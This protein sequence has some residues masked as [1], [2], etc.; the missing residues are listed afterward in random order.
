MIYLPAAWWIAANALRRHRRHQLLTK[1]QRQLKIYGPAVLCGIA[2]LLCWY[3]AALCFGMIAALL[4]GVP[5][6]L[7]QLA[8]GLTTGQV[9]TIYVSMT[10]G[11]LAVDLAGIYA[12]RRLMRW[13]IPE[14]SP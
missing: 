2:T 1:R 11:I 9:R 5:W 4:A 6:D 10:A 8:D 13:L 3:P 7:P 12:L 14:A